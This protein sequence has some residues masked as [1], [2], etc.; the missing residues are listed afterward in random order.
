MRGC[1]DTQV[2][3]VYIPDIIPKYSDQEQIDRKSGKLSYNQEM[4]GV[5]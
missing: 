5:K 2:N 1:V 4:K 3:K